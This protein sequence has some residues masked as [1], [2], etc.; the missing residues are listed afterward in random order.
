MLII[1]HRLEFP[2]VTLIT[3]VL[4]IACYSFKAGEA[5]FFG[6]P[7][8]YIYLDLNSVLNLSL[9]LLVVLVFSFGSFAWLFDDEGKLKVN[10]IKYV[11]WMLFFIE[12]LSVGFKLYKHVH[13]FVL[14]MDGTLNLIMLYMM[15]STFLTSINKCDE[16]LM[17]NLWGVV[18]GFMFMSA[19]FFLS[20]INYHNQLGST[21][22]V[23]EDNQ[24]VIGEYKDG[25]ILKKCVDGVGVFSVKD[26]KDNLFNETTVDLTSNIKFR[27]E[28]K[29]QVP[30]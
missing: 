11:I 2:V 16:G 4:F 7:S 28:K 6:Y 21:L 30:K 26:Y 29:I 3:A 20:G 24:Y 14:Y 9:K 13:D 23:T 15:V 25:F 12:A 19:A 22:W 18:V 10:S 8:Y 27:C 1:K 5:V 17:I